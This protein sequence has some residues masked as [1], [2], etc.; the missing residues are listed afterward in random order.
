MFMKRRRPLAFHW[1]KRASTGA[2]QSA[3]VGDRRTADRP[4]RISET[5]RGL[6]STV[7][8]KDLVI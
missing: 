6:R 4:A 1:R 5:W 3:A 7:V 2:S 8:A